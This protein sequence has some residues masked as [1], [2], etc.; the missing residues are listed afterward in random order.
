M[1]LG[2][3]ITT[4]ILWNIN[5]L[6]RGISTYSNKIFK[7]MKMMKCQILSYIF[8]EDKVYMATGIYI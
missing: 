4:F 7:S 1:K 5:L 3:Q 8:E 2:Y 6:Q